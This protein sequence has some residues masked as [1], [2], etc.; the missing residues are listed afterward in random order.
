[1][2]LI[3]TKLVKLIQLRPSV[4]IQKV[5]TTATICYDSESWYNCDHLLWFRKLIQLWPSVMIQYQY[6]S[7]IFTNS[8]ELKFFMKC[9]QI[10]FLDR[11]RRTK[12]KWRP[13]VTRKNSFPRTRLINAE[14]LNSFS[15]QTLCTPLRHKTLNKLRWIFHVPVSLTY[16]IK[17]QN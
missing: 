4:M 1:M 10:M 17:W 16:R 7:F 3:E 2:V 11:T 6:L 5:D 15:N 12:N 14:G 8:F 9:T 13:T